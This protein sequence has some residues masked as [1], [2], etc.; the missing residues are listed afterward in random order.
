MEVLAFLGT[1]LTVTG[2]I[3]SSIVYCAR[4]CQR[5]DAATIGTG[6]QIAGQAIQMITQ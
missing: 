4:R 3:I 2:F 6:A 5:G 1:C